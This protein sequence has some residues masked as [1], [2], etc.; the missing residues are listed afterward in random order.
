MGVLGSAR[1]SS[2][3]VVVIVGPTATGK[4]AIAV[5]VATRVDGEVISADSRA[6]FR[7]LQ[8]TTARLPVHAQRGI[9]HHLIGI[10]EIDENYDAM[11]FRESVDGLIEQ[12]RGRGHLP[13][14][15]GGGTLYLGAI[16]QGIFA[17]PSANRELRQTLE[18]CSLDDIYHE[19][20]AADPVAA[21]RIHPN[22]RL[23]IIRALEVYRLTGKRISDLQQQAT[24]LPYR[25]KIFGLKRDKDEHRRAIAA[26]VERMLTHGLV[27][28]V[29]QLRR[30]GLNQGCQAYRTIGVREV[31][32]LLDNKIT[33]E[34][35]KKR[36]ISNT[37][38]LVR[39]QKAWFR[40]EH[41]VC[42]ID[43][44]AREPWEIGEQI[45]Q[46]LHSETTGV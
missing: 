36:I 25:F 46:E 17:G 8:I 15:V 35:M 29:A 27:D 38:Q 10:V 1:V 33:Q 42:W 21:R 23:R 9:R 32:D 45:A 16:L 6:F 34:E 5:E 13:L 24:P 31:V 40:R 22:D 37:W 4:S 41:G 18:E 28:E 14:I 26:R 20:S 12:I 44:S 43:V 30:N 19:L 7:G 11:S 2:G 3:S 39:R